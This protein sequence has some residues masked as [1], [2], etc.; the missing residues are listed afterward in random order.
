MKKILILFMIIG[1]LP[2]SMSQVVYKFNGNELTID[3]GF[4]KR[5]ISCT[6]NKLVSAGLFLAG[7]ERNYLRSS[8]PEF[9]F[10]MNGV[11]VDGNAGWKVISCKPFQ[12]AKRGNRTVLNLKGE[13]PANGM[14]LSISYLTYPQLPVIRKHIKFR[15][16]SS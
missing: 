7:V 2:D 5:I 15:N 4:V 12:D 10:L 16:T 13:G 9:Q 6:D 3:N 11:K 14:E 8:S 1:L